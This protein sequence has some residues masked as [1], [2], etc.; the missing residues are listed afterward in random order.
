MKL[1][2]FASVKRWNI[3]I[4]VVKDY[5]TIKREKDRSGGAVKEESN[6]RKQ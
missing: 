6:S 5:T 1:C 3:C 2:L 4:T